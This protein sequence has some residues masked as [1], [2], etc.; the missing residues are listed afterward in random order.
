MLSFEFWSYDFI[1]ER[2][3]INRFI[4]GRM[5]FNVKFIGYKNNRSY[6]NCC[7]GIVM[8]LKREGSFVGGWVKA[9]AN[10]IWT[11]CVF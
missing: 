3:L 6:A 10:T 11:D 5:E 9:Y 8:N 4:F 2:R 1:A 7:V